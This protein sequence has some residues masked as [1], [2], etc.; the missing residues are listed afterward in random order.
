MQ[1]FVPYACCVGAVG[2]NHTVGDS[3]LLKFKFIANYGHRNGQ[4]Q[5]YPTGRVR[6]NESRE[7]GRCGGRSPQIKV[8]HISV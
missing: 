3:S 4:N 5:N 7:R 2:F 6:K 8:M 1:V